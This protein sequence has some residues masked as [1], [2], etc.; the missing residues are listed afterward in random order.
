MDKDTSEIIE[1]T[2]RIS[3]DPRSKLFV[4]LAEEYKKIGDIEMAIHVLSEGLKN[5]PAYVTAR[6]LLGRLLC[7]NGDLIAA[8]KEFEEVV[9]A[10]PDNLLAQKKLGD[11]YSLQKN[12]T[13]A[14]KHYQIA[15]AL[16]PSDKT[17]SALVAKLEE[18][19]KVKEGPQ[20]QRESD[21]RVSE[22]VGLSEQ[23]AVPY[24]SSTAPSL[25]QTP[26]A[27]AE[28]QSS[29]K[30]SFLYTSDSSSRSME[31]NA[32]N[33]I[34]STFFSAGMA[35]KEI[36]VFEKSE[37]PGFD[38][39]KEQPP[40]S[41]TPASER[42]E[43]EEVF[44]V[45]PLDEE[46]TPVAPLKAGESIPS[47][48]IQKIAPVEEAVKSKLSFPDQ[49][50]L[51][52]EPVSLSEQGMAT[53]GTQESQISSFASLTTTP[54]EGEAAGKQ[55]ADESDDFTTDTLAELY[56]V[57]GFYEKAIDIYQR[58]L[59]EL[60]DSIGLRDKLD[61]VRAM[62]M[63]KLPEEYATA[64]IESIEALEEKRE[65][66]IG[67][68]PKEYSV[69]M[70]SAEKTKETQTAEPTGDEIATGKLS[71]N[72]QIGQ[73]SAFMKDEENR[74][75]DAKE[76]KN[77]ASTGADTDKL[78]IFGESREYSMSKTSE[79][80][81]QTVTKVPS[82]D[83]FASPVD[84]SISFKHERYSDFEPKEY[85]PPDAFSPESQEEK[86]HG[87]PRQSMA[88]RKETIVRLENWLKN[89]KKEK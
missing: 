16:N 88:A 65:T 35:E 43:P 42:E 8:Q 32:E 31:K 47:E 73:T 67:E 60:P 10:I 39:K 55:M 34:K 13:E 25:A 57:Q 40:D 15:L 6:S 83:V 21:T 52:E 71:G 30:E 59:A 7:E 54:G 41:F 49:E 2:E 62:A 50:L 26:S 4:P 66:P 77:K 3:K 44:V 75:L 79:E 70:E 22:P 46:H 12:H 27:P 18:I 74:T 85:I 82:A 37:K 28:Q 58:M 84:Q 61:R 51:K 11:L 89:I 87:V 53:L 81:P 5:N 1:L 23:P 64:V 20:Q 17:V 14:L 86:V 24:N 48:R 69:P 9:K 38:P 19:D 63:K 36:P 45:E 72:E 78:N 29:V 33:S 56:I 68:E 80:Q 76:S